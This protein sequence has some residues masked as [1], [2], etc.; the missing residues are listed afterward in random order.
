MK[1]LAI[2]GKNLAS[3]AGE[4]EIDFTKEPLASAGI[5]AITGNTGAGKS[6]LLDAMCIALYA[7][8]PRIN[9][10]GNSS[11]ITDV[12]RYTIKEHD[13]RNILRKGTSNG[14]AEVDF[15][16][17]DNKL[18]RARWSVKR[19]RN[20]INGKMQDAECTLHS[21]T[22]N[23]I[24]T[25]GK[26]E[27]LAR[28]AELIGLTY[29]QFTRAVLLAQGDFATFLKAAPKEKAEILE[30]LTGSDIY[31]RISARIYEHWR[32]ADSEAKLLQQKIEEAEILTDDATDA[33]KNELAQLNRALQANE[34]KNAILEKKST[35]IEREE[36]LAKSLQ[37]AQE[38]LAATKEK[39]TAATPLADSLTLIDSVQDIRDT[40]T[41]AIETK[42]RIDENTTLL[43]KEELTI[44][45]LNK[46]H[47]QAEE[48]VTRALDAQK[49]INVEWLKAQPLIN[50]A[51]AMEADYRNTLALQKELE[52]KKLKTKK[53]LET[54]QQEESL[55]RK[56]IATAENE[57]K[58]LET[59]FTQ[60]ALYATIVPK[61]DI[62]I[63]NIKD[64]EDSHTQIGKR[65]KLIAEATTLLTNDEKRLKAKES[66]AETLNRMLPA[67]ITILRSRLVEG[68]PCPVCGSR[69]HETES[70]ATASL[71]ED[72]LQK[73]KESVADSIKLLQK[74]IEENKASIN[75]HRAY[76]ESIKE[77]IKN[78]KE[79]NR[80]ILQP[81]QQSTDTNAPTFAAHLQKTAA[82]WTSNSNRQ[83]AISENLA[84]DSTR[85]TTLHQRIAEK[86]STL[87]E[88]EQAIGN[89]KQQQ[90]EKKRKI[91][92]LIGEG[93]TA[94]EL[95]NKYNNRIIEINNTVTTAI[96]SRSNIMATRQKLL[97]SI[98]QTKK[99]LASLEAAQQTAKKEIEQYLS[100]RKEKLT[101][102]ELHT[103]LTT[104]SNE[105][106]RRRTT[107]E[108]LRNNHLTA[109]ATH[110]ER[111]K[112][113]E[114]HSKE[115]GK[116]QEG[117][118]LATIQ[119]GIKAAA[120]E[121]KQLLDSISRTTV[122][123]KTDEENKKRHAHHLEELEKKTST[124]NKWTIL[125]NTYGSA[126][127]DK[128]KIIAQGYT[129]DILL[130][131]ANK[132]LHD[133]SPR[134]RLARTTHDS[135][136]I[137]VIDADLMD[138]ERSVH[139]LSGGET[140]LVSL[141]LALS[142]SSLSSNRMSIESL[143]IDEGFG[144][145]DNET[146]RTAMEALERLQGQGRKVG[147]IS[148]LQDII[149]RIS[150]K[151]KVVKE[152][153]GKSKVCIEFS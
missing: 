126:I 105:I 136:G 88:S 145:L 3:L 109:T 51:L 61:S 11:N 150:A 116:P 147:V 91:T 117:E 16:A 28:I 96:E 8:S 52:E 89:N 85:L 12:G 30:K 106:M 59:W 6:T 123:I 151:I 107:V 29:E 127:G 67:E 81:L 73:A 39:L 121:K 46:E 101:L 1:I 79:R 65:E 133:I 14:Y 119:E 33:L 141:A 27:T 104:D 140:F 54:L 86:Q 20:D 4:F 42:H 49:S 24:L 98:A 25:G 41:S 31:S 148:H 112:A 56:S 115:S 125:N 37:Q 34:Q 48:K 82:Q 66:E 40:Y 152:Q 113:Y 134:Y 21:L 43:Q 100:N 44:E 78:S 58:E 143:F 120:E 153:E 124:L 77:N 35:W 108:T 135:L 97:G 75:S 9:K 90:E 80:E 129:L 142:L 63:T 64:I 70:I 5:Y 138:E 94:E 60:H 10:L 22:D 139:S 122:K 149:E 45:S 110:K 128:F 83:A 118:N 87:Q 7:T 47:T 62:I 50:Q 130:E 36:I 92:E 72:E 93:H 111:A 146:L 99:T 53:E 57:K 13:S 76:I 69:H 23:R 19:A 26:S 55:L 17:L 132:H 84:I 114:E 144:A 38:A 32:Q 103:L 71:K 2:R 95:N 102:Q 15:K 131:Y 137:K 68:E 74:S 18:Y